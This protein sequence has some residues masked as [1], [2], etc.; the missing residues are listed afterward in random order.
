MVKPVYLAW[1]N[2][3]EMFFRAALLVGQEGAC[4]CPIFTLAIR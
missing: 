4:V 2:R 1:L 3:C